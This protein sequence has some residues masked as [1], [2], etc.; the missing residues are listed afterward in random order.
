MSGKCLTLSPTVK[1]EVED[2]GLYVMCAEL[3][4]RQDLFTV[5]P[6]VDYEQGFGTR[7][8]SCRRNDTL[9]SW[10]PPPERSLDV[11][12]EGPNGAVSEIGWPAC[13]QSP[14]F[15]HTH[16]LSHPTLLNTSGTR[17]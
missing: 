16:A 11:T 5:V 10:I 8:S 9:G 7:T 17:S 15:L 14:Y 13:C 12:L 1:V 6:S 2:G 3:T 4:Y